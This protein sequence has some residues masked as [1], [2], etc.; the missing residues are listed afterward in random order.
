[1]NKTFPLLSIKMSSHL[2]VLLFTL[3][4]SLNSHANE[5]DSLRDVVMVGNNWEGT[6]DIFDPHTFEV[7]KRL[8][9][10]PMV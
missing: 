5:D 3:L 2:F 6:V 4:F 10:V 9:V 1:M 8:D 7:I